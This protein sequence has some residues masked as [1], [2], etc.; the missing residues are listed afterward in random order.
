MGRI[1]THT[2]DMSTLLTGLIQVIVG[3]VHPAH[4]STGPVWYASGGHMV[5]APRPPPIV[6]T[7]SLP[8]MLPPPYHPAPEPPPSPLTPPELALPTL[9]ACHGIAMSMLAWQEGGCKDCMFHHVKIRVWLANW[10]PWSRLVF[11]WRATRPAQLWHSNTARTS[12]QRPRAIGMCSP[13][14][15]PIRP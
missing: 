14:S 3:D 5:Y 7:P 9:T 8:P 10:I 2:R 15:Y 4:G 12:T 13:G 6:P 1:H 11:T